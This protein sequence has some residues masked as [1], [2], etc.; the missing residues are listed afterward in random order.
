MAELRDL[1]QRTRALCGDAVGAAEVVNGVGAGDDRIPNDRSR[2]CC[3]LH[4]NGNVGG[5]GDGGSE[6][7]DN[8]YDDKDDELPAY[9]NRRWDPLEEER[10]MAW[11]EENKPWKWIFGQFPDRA[12]APFAF[13]GTCCSESIHIED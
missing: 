9:M 11:R 3:H 7:G 6:N 10:L 12:E 5:S 8:G 4:R 1:C 13:G 2:R